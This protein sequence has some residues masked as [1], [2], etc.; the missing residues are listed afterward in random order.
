MEIFLIRANHSSVL[1]W[2]WFLFKMQI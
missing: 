1:V 2:L